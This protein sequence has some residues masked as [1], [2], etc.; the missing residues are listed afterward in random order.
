MHEHEIHVNYT[1]HEGKQQ[2]TLRYTDWEEDNDSWSILEVSESASEAASQLATRHQNRLDRLV[3]ALDAAGLI[4]VIDKNEEDRQIVA[5][6]N[7][8]MTAGLNKIKEL[9]EELAEAKEMIEMATDEARHYKSNLDEVQKQLRDA[10]TFNSELNETKKK[11]EEELAETLSGARARIK[12]LEVKLMDTKKQLLDAQIFNSELNETK[13]RLQEALHDVKFYKDQVTQAQDLA[14]VSQKMAKAALTRDICQM[15][16][17]EG[18]RLQP[19]PDRLYYFT[20][21]PTCELC[22]ADAKGE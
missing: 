12:D 17:C 19:Q 5:Q 20:V 6:F 16:L 4:N 13:K 1:N 21:D 18:T 3:T 2:V 22:V 9:E 11:L 7:N 14:E 15:R 8:A 10:Q